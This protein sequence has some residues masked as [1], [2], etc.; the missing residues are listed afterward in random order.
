MGFRVTSE[1]EVAGIDTIV[2]GEEGYQ[3]EADERV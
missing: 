1:D 3:L 2:H